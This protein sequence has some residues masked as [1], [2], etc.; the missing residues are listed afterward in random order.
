MGS[1][2]RCSICRNYF[3]KED[4]LRTGLGGLGGVCSEECFQIYIEKYKAKRI[5]RKEHREKKYANTGRRL[6]GTCRERVKK[7]DDGKCRWCGTDQEVQIHHVRYRSE[8]GP[9]T[10]RNLISICAECHALAHSNKKKYQPILLTWLWMFYIEQ[11]EMN[12]QSIFRLLKWH[13]TSHGTWVA[14]EH[15][16]WVDDARAYSDYV[17]AKSRMDQTAPASLSPTP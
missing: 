7:R 1:K 16:D 11:R 5:R 14:A 9:D 13:Q 4:M 12:V 6:P 2:A 3:L 17:Y 15:Q 10:P 8:G